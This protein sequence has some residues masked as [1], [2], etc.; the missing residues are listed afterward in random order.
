MAI[1]SAAMCMD[2]ELI[3]ELNNCRPCTFDTTREKWWYEIG[4]IDGAKAADVKNSLNRQFNELCELRHSNANNLR[5]VAELQEFLPFSD[6]TPITEDWLTAKFQNNA[7][8]WEYA[9]EFTEIEIRG[10]NDSIWNVEVTNIELYD[11]TNKCLVR[12]IGQ[13][14]QFLTLCGQDK[15]AKTLK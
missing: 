3:Q 2:Y 14:R 11:Y 1:I 5:V 6:T 8:I 13:L 10:Y 12:T 4:L 7:D 15:F 9:D